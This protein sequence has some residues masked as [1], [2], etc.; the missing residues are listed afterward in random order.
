MKQGGKRTNT[1][2]EQT[3]DEAVVEVQA[4]STRCTHC[5]GDYPRPTEG[6]AVGIDAEPGQQIQIFIEP[7]HVITCWVTGSTVDDL[8]R[9]VS[10][11]IPIAAAA[12]RKIALNL[13]GGGGHPHLESGRN[14]KIRGCSGVVVHQRLLCETC[15]PGMPG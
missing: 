2:L 15:C 5:A 8:A 10:E 4:R 7:V 11:V 14:I 6:E 13:P 9:G 1:A 3:V 12:A